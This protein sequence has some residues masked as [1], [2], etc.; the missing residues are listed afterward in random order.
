MIVVDASAL[1]E[2]LLRTS[3][4]QIVDRWLFGLGQTLHA[5]HLLDIEVA[6]T[7]RRYVHHGDIDHLRGA[8]AL[9]ALVDLS[10]RRYPHG[11]LLPRIWNCA[12]TSPHTTRHTSRSPRRWMRRC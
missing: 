1:L 7:V 6:Q 11:P 3:H 8:N 10:M 12:A 5:P 2:L 9:A 4:A